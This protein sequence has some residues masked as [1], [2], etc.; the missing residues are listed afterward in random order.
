MSCLFPTTR[1]NAL[2]VSLLGVGIN[3]SPQE[4]VNVL[5]KM[6]LPATVGKDG[7]VLCVCMCACV[8]V[9]V[10]VCGTG[11]RGRGGRDRYCS[12][13]LHRLYVFVSSE[14][15]A[16]HRTT[17]A[18]RHFAPVRHSGTYLAGWCCEAALRRSAVL[19]D[20]AVRAG[21]SCAVLYWTVLCS[22]VLVYSRMSATKHVRFLW[23]CDGFCVFCR[24]M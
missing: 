16:S 24:R 10:C 11:K 4:M 15:P 22:A 21:L 13:R 23:L 19:L 12:F 1:H 20:F 8:C 2:F 7:V 14:I 3:I 5:K 9:C 6:Q 18:S 17:D